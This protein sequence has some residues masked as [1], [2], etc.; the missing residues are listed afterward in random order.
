MDD[1]DI[2]AT[3]R[4]L[5]TELK[6]D[7]QK[8]FEA[9]HNQFVASALT[10][11]AGHEINPDFVIGNM[12]AH[13]TVY[14]LTPNPKDILACMD[15]DNIKNNFCGDVQV[16]GEY[17]DFIFR[18]FKEH[19]IDTSFITEEDK[20]KIKGIINKNNEKI[21]IGLKEFATSRIGY[22]YSKEEDPY[23]YFSADQRYTR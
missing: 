12:I 6:S 5:L 11:K 4:L 9:L 1:A 17:P 7:E 3:E 16:R 13:V 20:K 10:V 21:K 22:K 18:Y 14:P 23:Y 2:N 19:N 15:E 8:T